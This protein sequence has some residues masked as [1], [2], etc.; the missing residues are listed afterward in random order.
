MD[1]SGECEKDRADEVGTG[2]GGKARGHGV[3][4]LCPAEDG[5][6]ETSEE[7]SDHQVEARRRSMVARFHDVE[8]RREVV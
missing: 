2:E 7:K 4:R 3:V 1:S 5:R 8:E 6:R